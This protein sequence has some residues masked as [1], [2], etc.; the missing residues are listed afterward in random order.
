MVSKSV[1]IGMIGVTGA[2]GL[3]TYGSYWAILNGNSHASKNLTIW[4]VVSPKK[5]KFI[6]SVDTASHD[7]EWQEI[8]TSIS[9]NPKV[10]NVFGEKALTKEDLKN[11]CS[12]KKVQSSDDEELLEDWES[13]CT[14]TSNFGQLKTLKKE[15]LDEDDSQAWETNF[16]NYKSQANE[17]NRITDSSGSS[18][19]DNTLQNKEELIEWCNVNT[20]SLYKE[21]SSATK[22]YIQWCTKNTDTSQK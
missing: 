3:V 10:K 16:N 7:K 15:E 6:L 1:T 2:V 13:W 21:D 12:K 20:R 19:K 9:N 5:G 22:A 18:K 14:K 11:W 4:Q 17:N 8:V